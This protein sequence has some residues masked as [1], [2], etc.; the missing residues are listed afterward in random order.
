MIPDRPSLR[1]VLRP[2]GPV[3]FKVTEHRRSDATVL[4]IAG[5]IDVLTAPKLAVH[6]DELVRKRTGDAILDLSETVFIDSSGLH[7]LLN[8][9]RRLTRQSRKMAVVCKP[10]PVLRVIELARL[11]DTLGVIGSLPKGQAA[12]RIARKLRAGRSAA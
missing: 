4:D 2:R 8:A 6:L 9:Q 5:E 10:G 11:S 1:G 7:I 3:N 12:K